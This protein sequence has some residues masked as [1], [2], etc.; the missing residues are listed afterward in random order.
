MDTIGVSIALPEPHAATLQ[1]CREM[2]GDP[3]ATSIPTHIT[4]LPPT[5]IAPECRPSF[6]DHLR[7]VCEQVDPFEIQLRGTGTFRPVSPVVFVQLATGMAECEKLETA[8][9][10]GPLK[11]E[12]QFEYHPHVTV[13]HDID[14]E[15]LD[16]AFATLA[17]Y[18]GAFTAD[19][20]HLYEHGTDGVWRPVSRFDFHL[21]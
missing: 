7:S 16:H 12:L 15:A 18:E 6:E 8:V 13:A 9:R 4:I 17:L 20:V 14:D 11:R 5:L 21:R 3:L 19:A 2:F 10:S 1:R